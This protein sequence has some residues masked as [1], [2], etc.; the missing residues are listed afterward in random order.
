MFSKT[1]V[2]LSTTIPTANAKP[3]R[4]MTFSDRPNS[5]ITR[6]VPISEIGIV[7]PMTSAPRAYHN[8]ETAIS[9]RQTANQ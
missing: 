1:T 9:S 5:A 6:N 2:A 3:A 4:L 7:S 8:P